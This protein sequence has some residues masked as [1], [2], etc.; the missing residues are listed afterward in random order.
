M[1][2]C[3]NEEW[4]RKDQQRGGRLLIERGKGGKQWT[5][6]GSGGKGTGQAV[7]LSK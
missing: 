7:P 3:K 6:E 4:I 2:G 5:G 1:S